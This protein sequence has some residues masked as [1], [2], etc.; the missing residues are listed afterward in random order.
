MS[1]GVLGT[2]TGVRVELDGT[3]RLVFS[4]EHGPLRCTSLEEW[5]YSRES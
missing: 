4:D 1:V 2:A 5:W 3:F